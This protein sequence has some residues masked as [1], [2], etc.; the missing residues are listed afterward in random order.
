MARYSHD[1]V[2]QYLDYISVPVEERAFAYA[3]DPEER[4]QFLKRLIYFQ[5]AKVPFENLSLHYSP[6]RTI[7]MDIHH[8]FDKMVT[9]QNGRGGYCMEINTFFASILR[10][11]NFDVISVGG[12]ISNAMKPGGRILDMSE[13]EFGSWSHI[14][15]IVTVGRQRFFVDCGFGSNGPTLPVPLQDGFTCRNTGDSS[16]GTEL[17]LQRKHIPGNTHNTANQLLWIYNVRFDETGPW[18]P[19][20]CFPELEFLPNDFFAMNFF[21]SNSPTSWFTHKIVCM[22]FIVDHDTGTVLGEIALF[23]TVVKERRYGKSK[24]LMEIK[25]EENRVEA[26]RKY[27]NIKLS[28]PEINGIKDVVTMI[29]Q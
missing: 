24:T 4:L 22:K 23:E 15:N 7:S 5:L 29:R 18:I 2:Q 16:G 9:R 10:S 19:R 12:R 21:V 13:L 25:S 11:L 28:L 6:D 14:L 1:Q 8:L 26:L 20:Y 17:C 3:G 27:F